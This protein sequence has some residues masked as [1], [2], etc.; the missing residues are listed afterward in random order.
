MV[1]LH[2][3]NSWLVLSC[4]CFYWRYLFR[5]RSNICLHYCVCP[6]G[7]WRQTSYNCLMHPGA[8]FS[9]LHLAMDLNPGYSCSVLCFLKGRA[10]WGSQSHIFFLAHFCLGAVDK[11]RK[12]LKD[13]R[14]GMGSW[15][16]WATSLA[17]LRTYCACSEILLEEWGLSSGTNVRG[18]YCKN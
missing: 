7:L 17:E 12:M 10:L 3:L 16:I 1:S 9:H 15:G 8:A 18:R 6:C 14:S 4:C 5:H 11:G 13:L 2:C